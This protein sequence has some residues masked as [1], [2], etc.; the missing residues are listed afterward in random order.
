MV[1]PRR[2]NSGVRIGDKIYL[3]GGTAYYPTYHERGFRQHATAVLSVFDLHTKQWAPLQNLPAS[4]DTRAVKFKGMVC[5]MGGYDGYHTWKTFQCYNTRTG[6]WGLMP[7]APLPASAHSLAVHEDKLYAFG[8]Y[9]QMSQV[10][11][12]NAAN[13]QWSQPSIPFQPARHAAAVTFGNDIY[14]IGGN[15]GSNGPY[16]DK[17]QVFSVAN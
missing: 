10:E 15:T 3:V 5:A 11:M 14:V 6:Q 9:T 8:D 1:L 7:D 12:Y 13:H 2:T 17:I 16:L 4:L